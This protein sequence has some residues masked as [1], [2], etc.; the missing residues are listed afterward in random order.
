ILLLR[1]FVL[2]EIINYTPVARLIGL[3]LSKTRKKFIKKSHPRWRG[4]RRCGVGER[5]GVATTEDGGGSDIRVIR[6]A[7]RFFFQIF[8]FTYRAVG[9]FAFLSSLISYSPVNPTVQ[10]CAT[11]NENARASA[12]HIA[13]ATDRTF[14]LFQS[15]Y[16]HYRLEC[17]CTRV[18]ARRLA[19]RNY[20]HFTGG[21]LL[22]FFSCNTPRAT[23]DALHTTDDRQLSSNLFT[24]GRTISERETF[25]AHMAVRDRIII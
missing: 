22:F 12:D 18:R 14:S 13:P 2:N 1:R 3:D 15:Y 25:Y 6:H 10:A 21:A 7:A 17:Y 9:T 8:L 4:C 24:I 11:N 16:Y 23:L 5:Q 20:S 19:T